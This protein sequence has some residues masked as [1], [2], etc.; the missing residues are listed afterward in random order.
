MPE[1][2]DAKDGRRSDFPALCAEIEMAFYSKRFAQC[3]D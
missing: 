3:C 1:Q 2:L